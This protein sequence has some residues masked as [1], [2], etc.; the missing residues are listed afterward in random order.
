MTPPSHPQLTR[1][2][3]ALL[4]ISALVVVVLV[5]WY[6]G[7]PPKTTMITTER[8]ADN[9]IVRTIHEEQKQRSELI[10]LAGLGFAA[11]LGLMALFDGRLKLTGPGGAG[12]ELVATAAAADAAIAPLVHENEELRERLVRLEG[13]QVA[14]TDPALRDALDRW[15]D[16]EAR[17]R[18]R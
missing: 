9:R 8:D 12:I 15:K 2:Q 18:R 13:Q 16:V 11:I 14:P 5:V 1:A 3:K 4:L 6:I 17:I 7:S 10:M